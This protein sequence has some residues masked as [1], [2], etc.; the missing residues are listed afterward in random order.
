MN[1]H[2]MISR[3]VIGG[4]LAAFALVGCATKDDTAMATKKTPAQYVS[5]RQRLMKLHGGVWKDIQDKAKAGQV[6][7]IE[8]SA[9]TLAI[10]AQLIPSYFP[11]GA[12]T[13]ESKAK[14]EV[15]TNKADFEAAARKMETEAIRLR[16]AAK[17]KNLPATQAIVK[18]FGRNACGACHTPFRV[19]PAKS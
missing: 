12:M 2:S 4:S 16:D 13:P 19:P 5:E 15:F 11:E 7:A 3:V 1:R 18:D 8:V 17:T 6:E 9:E 10:N 14:P